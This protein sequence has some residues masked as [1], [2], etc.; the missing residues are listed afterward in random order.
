MQRKGRALEGGT[1]TKRQET[2]AGQTRFFLLLVTVATCCCTQFKRGRLDSSWFYIVLHGFTILNILIILD[3][4]MIFQEEE[5]QKAESERLQKEAEQRA[6]EGAGP[7]PVE[8]G[9]RSDAK[10]NEAKWKKEASDEEEEITQEDLEKWKDRSLCILGEDG[11]WGMT[12][13]RWCLA[14]N[15]TQ[16]LL[17]II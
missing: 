1:K 7:A 5:K 11:R 3:H 2:E 4:F 8:L 10:H 13:R 6:E 14:I 17:G 12:R 15:C 9:R 16:K